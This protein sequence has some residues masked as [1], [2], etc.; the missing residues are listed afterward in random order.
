MIIK[1]KNSIIFEMPLQKNKCSY[2][3]KS[4]MGMIRLSNKAQA[5]LSIPVPSA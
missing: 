1:S 2:L 4:A 3:K 5:D